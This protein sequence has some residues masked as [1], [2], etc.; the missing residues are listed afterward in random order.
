[1]KRIIRVFARKTA[2][3]PIDNMAFFDEPGLFIPEHKEVHVCCVFTWDI[4][5][6]KELQYQWQGTTKKPVLLDGPAFGNS[7]GDFTPGMYIKKGVTFTSRGCPNKCGFC[8][9]PKR[10]T[11]VERID[12]CMNWEWEG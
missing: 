7:N 8:F 9:V 2:L 5:R 6:A 10:E 1:M 3:T 4:E 12:T 11:H